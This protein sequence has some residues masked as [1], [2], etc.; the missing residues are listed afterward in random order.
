MIIAFF[1]FAQVDSVHFETP[2]EEVFTVLEEPAKFP[3]GI[4]AF[5]TFLS[6]NVRYP[7]RAKGNN[8]QG[9]VFVQFI[10]EK[11]GAISNLKVVK[12]I[13][14]G[15]DEETIRVLKLMPKWNPGKRE[16]TPV[17]QKMIQ[18]ISFAL[19]EKRQKGRNKN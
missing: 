17:R 7:K 6:K 18:P 4:K 15:C 12:G 13:G 10:V 1:S 11:D 8:V 19:G 9:R 3:G 2:E 14:S 16:G 5:Y